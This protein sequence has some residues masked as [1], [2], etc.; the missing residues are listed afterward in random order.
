MTE[1]LADRLNAA[2]AGRY[3]IERQLGQGGMAIVFLAQDVRHDRR[4]ALKVLRP[5]LAAAIGAERFLREIRLTANLQHP[6]ILPLHDSGEA[7]GFLFYVMPYVEG[8]SLRDWLNRERQLPVEDATRIATHVAAALSYAHKQGVI[9]RDI[10][11][12]NILLTSGTAVVADFGIA[13]ALTEAGAGRLTET[14][15]SLGTPQYMSPEQITAERDLDGR[16]DVYALGCVVYEMLAGEPPYTGPTA[17][18]VIAKVLTEPP[19]R[20]SSARPALPAHVAA[21]IHKAMAKLPADRFRSAA[22]FAE[23][24]TSRVRGTETEPIAAGSMYKARGVRL[25]RG[26]LLAAGAVVLLLGAMAIAGWLRSP[27]ATSA[28]VVRLAL[29]LPEDARLETR[30]G[31][32]LAFSP[33]G[34]ALVYSSGRQLFLRRLD[35]I[36]PVPLRSTDRGAQP[37]FSPDGQN[38]GFFSDG[39]LKR[40]DLT[41]GP[42]VTLAPASEFMGATWGPD[43]TIVFSATGGLFR[44]AASGGTA[45]PIKLA[46]SVPGRLFRWPEFLPDGKRLLVTL[47]GTTAYNTVGLVDLGS[48]RVTQL[49]RDGEPS[50]NPHFVEPNWLLYIGG[51]ATIFAAPFDLRRGRVT[52]NGIPVLENVRRG[53]WGDAKLAL[54]RAGWAVYQ[55]AP[56]QRR[57]SLVDRRGIAREIPTESRAFSDPRFSPDGRHVAVTVLDPGQ[58]LAG[59]IW[60]VE[61]SDA[62]LSR[63]TFGGLHQFAEWFADGRQLL[64]VKRLSGVVTAPAGGGPVETVLENPRVLEAV[65]THDGR[66]LVYRAP[67]V[68]GDLYYVRR[69]SLNHPHPFAVSPFDE[70]AAALS[71]DD[72]WLAYVSNETGRDEIYVRPFP[73][74]GG[75]WQVSAAGGTEPRW[76]RDSQELYYRNAD[77]LIAVQVSTRPG[78]AVGKR[79]P[80]FTGDYVTSTRHA[81]YDIHPDGQRF[82]FVTGDRTEAT[83]LV[84]VQNLFAPGR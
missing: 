31:S 42:A 79:A 47:A 76:R 82:L 72:R 77:T 6:H 59:D 70:R 69:D 16:S 35:Q 24:L 74:G 22:E 46:D 10:K 23:A 50:T 61:P 62:S 66:G 26:Q 80:L 7:G 58:G 21:A 71:L 14:G 48:R 25:E 44:V 54:S 4:V 5:E 41:G 53:I 1:P 20:V 81:T 32:P 15:L 40:V 34:S 67:G 55:K 2:L 27:R 29:T 28:P 64:I 45:E 33:D 9:H 60:T 57:L 12:E 63:L 38:V 8:E 51:E 18:S 78:F 37:F 49:G 52:G 3:T 30:E 83:D 13:R 17:Q 56:S 19:R 36:D 75:R 65:P 73:E 11:P 39:R 84:L 68:P 43:D